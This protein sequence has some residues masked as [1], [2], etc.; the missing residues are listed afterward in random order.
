MTA[1]SI[2][3]ERAWLGG[4]TTT[5]SVRIDIG[6]GAITA[7]TANTEPGDA[8]RRAGV[9]IPGMA[10]A[11]SHVFHR[12]LRGRTH[13]GPGDF[14]TWRDQMYRVAERLDPETLFR[15]AR[16]AYAEMVASGY[17]TVAEFH[18]L[19]HGPG[20]VRYD[21]P[22]V[23]GRAIAAAA[24]EA[25]IRLTLLDTCYLHGGTDQ[26]LEG[27]QLRFGDGSSRDWA[28]RVGQ[29]GDAAG[30]RVG[31]AIHSIRACRPDEMAEV[32]RVA[33]G[34][35]LHAHVSE[36]PRENNEALDR[37]GATPTALL[38][39]AGVLG[40]SFTAVHA[41]HVTPTDVGLLARSESTVCLCPTT[42]RDL[43]DGVAPVR[44]F[45]DAGIG[46]SIGSDSNAVIDPLEEARSVDLSPR[47]VTMRRADVDP[48]ALLGT[49][50]RHDT[51]GWPEV[52]AIE[53]GRRADLVT[54]GFSS[55][56]LAGA[57]TASI[58][59]VVHVASADDI[60]SVTVDGTDVVRGGRYRRGDLRRELQDVIEGLFA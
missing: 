24:R 31:A 50:T 6:D 17:T 48:A 22:N 7:V 19:H 42:E 14:W 36:Q 57:D 52:G 16:A 37:F 35:P 55:P 38:S 56:R 46:I 2:W 45:V 32:A 13:D 49:A 20:G 29:L 30:L 12:A 41:T 5:P 1:R 47:L 10:N 44:S 11:H 59:S 51:I 58:A 8:Q 9:T 53:V 23:M 15:L 60:E 4:P 21:D 28:E 25:G 54:I 27:P 43:A 26:D 34:R 40:P 18:Y 33:A 3:C 39:D